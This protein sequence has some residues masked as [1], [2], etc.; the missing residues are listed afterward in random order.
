[1]RAATVTAIVTTITWIIF[2]GVL[3]RATPRI[4]FYM[5]RYCEARMLLVP[6]F[7]MLRLWR[8]KKLSLGVK[9]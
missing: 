3:G 6:N 9:V 8:S 2:A 5:G 1:M 7:P 4:V